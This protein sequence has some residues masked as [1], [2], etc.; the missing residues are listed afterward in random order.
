[1]TDALA[2]DAQPADTGTTRLTIADGIATILFDRPQARNAMTW[3]MYEELYAACREITV[4]AG[5]V[6]VA[7]LRGVGGRAFVA[8]TDIEQFRTFTA[9]DAVAYEEKVEACVAAL[10]AIP[11]PTL[12]VVEG[13]AV[14]GGFAIANACDLRIATPGSRF[15]VPIARTLGNGL[16]ASN[17]RRLQATLGLGMVKRMLLLAEMPVAEAM[18]A[19][20]VE[21]VSSEALDGH[22]AEVCARLAGHAPLTMQATKDALNRL[23]L[24]AAPPDEDLIR[25]VYGSAD[26]KEGIAAFTAKRPPDWQGR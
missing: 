5:E 25:L 14:G 22:L 16:S 10:E 11:V 7:V 19:G 1:M 9:D 18:P 26:F 12:A 2:A 15:G 8:G 17:L 21:V 13:W 3:R 24:E 23:A 20:Y 6:K 4:R